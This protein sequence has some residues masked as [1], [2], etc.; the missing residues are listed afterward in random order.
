MKFLC[1]D[2]NEAMK[3]EST[4]GPDNGSMTVLFRCPDCGRATAMLTNA[5]ETQM[6]HSLGVKIGGRTDAPRPMETIR[7]SL[8]HGAQPPNGEY[9][10][11]AMGHTSGAD[12]TTSGDSE[13][14]C[15]F[16]SAVA[17][18]IE[19]S[20]QNGD[21]VWTAEASARMER[22]PMFVRSMVRKRIEEVAIQQQ[23]REIDLKVLEEVRGEMGM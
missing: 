12:P 1:V 4:S 22:I 16:S 7:G 18:S 17:E 9:E 3:L 15:P 20:E 21:I 14:K 5:M 11:D 2:C 13:S 6:V 23:I 10:V 19:Q 8:S